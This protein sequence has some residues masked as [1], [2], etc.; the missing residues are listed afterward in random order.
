MDDASRY[1]RDYASICGR[2][3]DL[4]NLVEKH[5]LSDKVISKLS[6]ELLNAKPFPYLVMD[7]LFSPELL[8]L[9]NLEFDAVRWRQWKV[10]EH[11]REDRRGTLPDVDFGLASRL[12]FQTVY[13]SAVLSFLKKLTCIPDLVTDPSLLNG[14][15]HEIP[16]GGQFDV[17]LDYTH[18]PITQ[19][20]NRMVLI[21]FLNRDWKHEY[22]G[23]LQLWN[24]QTQKCEVEIVPEFGRTVLFLNGP[25]SYHGCPVPVAA[26]NGRT[27]RSAAAYFYSPVKQEAPATYTSYMGNVAETKALM[28]TIRYFLPP[29]L[30]DGSRRL[31]QML[32]SAVPRNA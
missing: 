17:H 11:K 9:M 2:N 10:T 24:G 16:T 6:G 14:G 8:E 13:S 7:G 32:G 23:Q 20:S 30:V 19:L 22:G 26:P 12:Y 15:F 3:V 4:N 18:H 5:F 31:L 27:R 21:T 25:D 1:T 29:V 28:R